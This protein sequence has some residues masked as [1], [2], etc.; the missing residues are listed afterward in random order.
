[1]MQ[2]FDPTFG[3]FPDFLL[4]AT[5]EIWE[6]R[7]LT[8]RARAWYHPEVIL[9]AGDGIQFGAQT[10]AASAM[11][12]LVSLPDR[13]LL[14][15]DVIWSGNPRIGM[16]GSQRIL[17][18]A[19]HGGAGPLGP[20][21]GR[22]LRYREIIDSYAKRD[23]I[24]D[25]W[26]VTDTGAILRQLGLTAEAWARR[27]VPGLDPET[28]P[29]TPRVDVTG[30]YTG[31]GNTDQWGEGYAT[32]LGR[33]MDG[34]LSVIRDQ[35]DR[36]C[37]LCHPGGVEAHGWAAADAFWLGLRAAL[38]SAR[39]EIHHKIGMEEPQMP[40]RAA[41]RWSLTGRHEGW[42]AFGRPSGADLHVM[43]ISHA[44]FGPWGLRRE[45]TVWDEAAVWTQIVAQT[46]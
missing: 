38:P 7:G 32:L 23:Q 19:T 21:T 37:H 1:M 3:S 13:R 41:L 28:Q 43:G 14:G 39:F 20:P 8:T 42:G 30:P 26:T 36:A 17:S 34:D 16:L 18:V 5:R 12:T 10:V 31:Q 25:V 24:C 44:E 27:L 11:A 15:E 46:G 45:W 4:T 6:G 40:P 33:I 29:F 35:Y 22:V 9:R 2:G